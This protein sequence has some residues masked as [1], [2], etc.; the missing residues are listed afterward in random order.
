MPLAAGVSR[1]SKKPKRD[2][3][4]P[5]EKSPKPNH[6]RD[7]ER[8]LDEALKATF[9][10]SDPVAIIDPIVDVLKGREKNNPRALIG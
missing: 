9:P 1:M 3:P 6:Q 5:A 10:A 7:L 8:D 2:K 4:K